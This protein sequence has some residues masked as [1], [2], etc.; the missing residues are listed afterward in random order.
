MIIDDLPS[1]SIANDSDEIAIEQGTATKKITKGNFLQEITSAISSLLSSLS[2]KVSKAGDTMNGTLKIQSSILDIDTVP[3]NDQYPSVE[4]LADKNNKAY[5]GLYGTHLRN[6]KLGIN[7]GCNRTVNGTAIYNWLG[8]LIDPSGNPAIATAYPSA[9]R[10][11][12]GLAATA[13]TP[14][15]N[16]TNTEGGG[17]YGIYDPGAKTVR[18]YGWARNASGIPINSQMFSIPSAYRPSATKNGVGVYVYSN[19][20]G[21]NPIAVNSNGDITQAWSAATTYCAFIIEY[22]L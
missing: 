21:T 1:I 18:I 14:T 10:T 17:A 8:L 16:T 20:I 3:S 6:D 4:V 5:G 19:G 22:T 7:I 2:N 15:R 9:W 11:A 12:L 13:F